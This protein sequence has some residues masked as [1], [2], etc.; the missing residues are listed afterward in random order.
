ML[1][2]VLLAVL[3]GPAPQRR[4]VPLRELVEDLAASLGAVPIVSPSVDRAVPL[5]P[6]RATGA[7]LLDQLERD[8][9]L[10][11]RLENGRLLVWDPAREGRDEPDL[12]T[13]P[14]PR[15]RELPP[16]RDRLTYRFAGAGATLTVTLPRPA[17]SVELPGCGPVRIVALPVDPFDGER[18]LF[19]PEA[20][21]CRAEAPYIVTAARDVAGAVPLPIGRCGERYAVLSGEPAA[22]QPDGGFPAGP[23]PGR[24]I[25]LRAR[26]L[27]IDAVRETVLAE[28][29][30]RFDAADE[31]ESTTRFVHSAPGGR[32]RPADLWI[33]GALLSADPGRFE[34]ALAVTFT[35]DATAP[36]GT[37]TL[38]RMAHQQ[39]LLTARPGETVRQTLSSTFGQGRSALVLE[40]AVEERDEAR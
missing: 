17:S 32:A 24:S 3:L 8:L 26:L 10:S 4:E 15:V 28:P 22:A 27:E 20:S 2:P 11:V 25:V 12:L 34:L 31:L 38:V 30:V 16:R 14:L 19:F 36:G 40:V 1:V 18:R 39:G 7:A 35:L 6:S 37:R 5:D 29:T 21:T 9:G 13:L 23:A 33:G